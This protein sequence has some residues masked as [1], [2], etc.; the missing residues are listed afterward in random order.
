MALKMIFLKKRIEQ[1]S[2]LAENEPEYFII[3]SWESYAY[4]SAFTDDL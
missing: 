3:N 1:L 4:W 2:E